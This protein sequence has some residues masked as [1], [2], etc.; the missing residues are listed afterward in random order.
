MCSINFCALTCQSCKA[1]FR[2]NALKTTVYRCR[3]G[4]NCHINETTRRLCNKCR[5]QKCFAVGM[6]KEW[7][8]ND[9]QKK[10]RNY[11]IEENRK[12]KQSNHKMSSNVDNKNT[13]KV[14][15]SSC[16]TNDKTMDTR[17]EN[18]HD[19][20]SYTNTD[21][22][23]I[24]S[25]A[26]NTQ[27]NYSIIT[28]NDCSS[29]IT[30]DKSNNRCMAIDILNCETT[31]RLNNLY[32]F[33]PFE[34]KQ[35]TELFDQK[36]LSH[37]PISERVSMFTTTGTTE[38]IQF[39]ATH[40]DMHLGIFVQK[41]QRLSGFASQCLND[42]IAMVKYNCIEIGLLKSPMEYNVD[43]EC[44]Q[45]AKDGTTIKL[46]FFKGFNDSNNDCI[47]K[48]RFDDNCHINEITRRLC[49]KCRLKKCFAVGMKKEWILNDEQKKMRNNRIEENRKRKQSNHRN[50]LNGDQNSPQTETNS[51]DSN[52][53][54][55][56]F[57]EH[58][59][60]TGANLNLQPTHKC[61][62][63]I[64]TIT[65]E[66]IISDD[67]QLDENSSA[68]SS[69]YNVISSVSN[70][71]SNCPIITLDDSSSDTTHNKS[72]NRCMAIDVMDYKSMERINSLYS[73]NPF[74]CKLITEL[75]D[76]RL[77]SDYPIASRDSMPATVSELMDGRITGEL[78]LE[79]FKGFKGR[80]YDLLKIYLNTFSLEFHQ[81][82]HII[83]L[84]IPIILFNPH[85]PNI[86]NKNM[87]ELQHQLYLNT[88]SFPVKCVDH[89]C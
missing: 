60:K 73:F 13:S 72:N 78:K 19:D 39:N 16:D 51:C 6:K 20:Y 35:M 26:S 82:L 50:S 17:I 42:Q 33:N 80:F 48:C 7:I 32:S 37:Y 81:D 14:N 43:K 44:W 10:M 74:E 46:D 15:I 65:D 30:H 67:K 21:Q 25:R 69:Q 41:M 40:F 63:T 22:F 56:K 18:K 68:N 5:L 11:R 86:I 61:N 29:N 79:F 1:F 28:I 54:D 59:L 89:Y 52:T 87:V 45:F 85:Q 24:I 36:F 75:F 66:S 9:E 53:N 64:D 84:L 71:S 31:D 76:R 4:D 3:F 34:C 88:E 38:L 12:Q 55:N 27:S 49:K 58:V 8:L 2:R 70:T 77:L 57:N 62:E 47:D 83:E 23:T